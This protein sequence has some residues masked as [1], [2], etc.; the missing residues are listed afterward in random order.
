V[1]FLG[2]KKKKY[3]H[4]KT[5]LFSCRRSKKDRGFFLVNGTFGRK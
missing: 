1:I 5:V 2:K 3:H 4:K